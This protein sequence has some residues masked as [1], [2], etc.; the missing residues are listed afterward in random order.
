[1]ILVPQS[2]RKDMN[3]FLQPLVDKLKELWESGLDMRDT[4][5]DNKVFKMQ[6]VLLWTVND[7]LARSSL[8]GWS[9]QA[10]KACPTCNED[11]PSEK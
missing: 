4:A 6:E 1:M 3:V 11:T 9:G 2:P 5:N 7:F 10:Y 8:L